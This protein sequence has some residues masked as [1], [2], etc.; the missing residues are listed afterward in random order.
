MKEN[1]EGLAHRLLGGGVRLEE[2]VEILERSMIE[3]ALRL[4]KNNQSA[5]AKRLGIHRNTLL[6]KMTEY[7]IGNGRTL[8][9]PAG[10]SARSAKRAV[11]AA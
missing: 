6:R 5:A 4:L 1:L 3:A 7:E 11:S 8:R 2:S 9:K 10:R